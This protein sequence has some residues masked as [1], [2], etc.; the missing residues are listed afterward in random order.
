M[1]KTLSI[2]VIAL[3]AL[4][5]AGSAW[6]GDEK[7][8]W[9]S[10]DGHA[11]AIHSGHAMFISDEGGENFDLSDLRNGES[12]TF[13]E[14]DKQITATRM[15][16][17]VTINRDARGDEK[18]LQ[19]KCAVDQDTCQ[20]ITFDDDPE[21]VMIVVKKTRSCINDVGDCDAT[22][23]ITLDRLGNLDGSQVHA[24]VR[25]IKCDD[26]GNCEET[27]D[28]VGH[29][30][31][32]L[33]EVIADFDGTD[34]HGNVMILESGEAAFGQT[35]LRCPEGDSTVRVDAEEADDTFLCPKH[36]VPMEKVSMPHFIRKIHLEEGD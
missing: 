17:V 23:D 12:R 2:V 36:S 14:G 35:T 15:D 25:K 11:M 20:V 1:R 32:G 27:E 5:I 26:E 7:G 9:V 31:H 8:T 28:V 3:L 18:A 24:I 29:G 6:G 10:D 34:P 21:K 19:I 33:V 4:G 13:G 22:V 16:D 30:G